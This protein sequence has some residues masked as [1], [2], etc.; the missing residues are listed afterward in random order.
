MTRNAPRLTPEKVAILA[1][2]LLAFA[3]RLWNLDGVPPGWRDDELI[4]SLVISQ[5]VLDGNWAVYYP[6]ASGH[7]ALYHALNAAMLGA[8][9]PGVPG[10]RWLSVLLGTLTVPLTYLVGRRLFG[11]T[12]GLVAAT[13]LAFSFWSLMYSRIGLRHIST[14]VLTL[15]AFYFF[16]RG[17]GI[18]AGRPVM[19]KSQ[20]GIRDFLLAAVFMGLNFY[21]YFASRGVP[22][23]L[24]AFGVYVGLVA[25]PLLWRR[26][27]GLVLMFGVA[28]LLALPL[29]VT[30][31]R[32]PE[33]EGRV[34]E[35]AVPL[36]EARAGNFAPLQHH[37]VATLNMFHSDGDS[38]WLYNI[39]HRPIF[40]VIGALFFWAGVALAAVYALRALYFAARRKEPPELQWSLPGAFLLLWWVAGI[41]PAFISVPPGS[42]GHTILAQPAVYILA[43]LPVWWVQRTKVGEGRPLL[44]G[45][46][47]VALVASV[48]VRDLPAYFQEW[49]QRGMVRFLYRADIHDVAR[50]LDAHPQVTDFGVTG[51]LAGP[52]D[53]LALAINLDNPEN[54][55]PRWYNPERALLL[56]PNVSF[57]GYPA[58]ASPYESAFERVPDVAGIGGYRL[59]RVNRTAD[60]AEEICF[61][62]GL[63]WISAVYDAADGRL[64]LGWRVAEPLDLPPMPLISNPPP[65]G[66]YAGPRLYV[67]AQLQDAAGSFLVGDDGLWVDPA[68]LRPGDVFVQQHHLAAPETLAGVTAVFGLYDPMTGE[69]VLTQDGRDFIRVDVAPG[70]DAAP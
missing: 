22:L 11:T 12:V 55:A 34:S 46:L 33:A 65:P 57:S 58:V 4:N 67:F 3:L 43:A 13:A 31:S 16:L 24:L 52:W 15:A 20:S 19:D 37:V 61:A 40:G 8:F 39:P 29:A 64:E 2:T 36:T 17:L 56:R 25:R 47:V 27:R 60:G 28:A 10:I 32:Q 38:E 51:L 42:L 1:L 44:V 26:W 30:L 5:K 48:A 9:G 41:A 59:N 7:E 49:P 70:E 6:D 53:K 50:Y 45:L 62:N 35:L 66:V 54:Y 21:T 63:C 68:T 18:G 23:I 14:P 69:R